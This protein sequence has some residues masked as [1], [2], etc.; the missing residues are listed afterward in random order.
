MYWALILL[1]V[2]AVFANQAIIDEVNSKQNLWVAGPSKFDSWSEDEIRGMLNPMITKTEV[3]ETLQAVSVPSA[4][5]FYEQYATCNAGVMDQAKC[6]SCWA[7]GTATSTSTRYC[8]IHNT[9]MKLSP[10]DLV[11]C[12]IEGNMGCNGGQPRLACDYVE[13]HGIVTNDCYPY[14]SGGGDSG[15]CKTKCTG[16]KDK[17]W[18]LY[19]D[20]FFSCSGYESESAIQ[21][22]IYEDGPVCGTMTV[23]QDFMSYKGGVYE[24]TTGEEL[25]GHAITIVGWGEDNGTKY[26]RVQNSWGPSW[27]EEGFFRIVRGK[28][29]CGIDSGATAGVPK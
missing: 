11:S 10:Q 26:W 24:H 13:L 28:N 3:Q 6:G 14:T 9:Q 12:D 22:A 29:N 16:T 8:K 27:G 25:G 2:S 17:T 4:Y 20:K 21:K 19:K 1:L 15:S 7:F 5:D 18:K 23:Y